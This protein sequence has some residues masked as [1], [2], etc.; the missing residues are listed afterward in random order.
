M[1]D[2]LIRATEAAIRQV[3]DSRFFATE[4]GFH[5]RFYCALQAQLERQ[6]ILVDG[7]IL[8][9]EYQKSARH[10]IG[11]RPDIVL[12][13]PA[14]QSGMSVEDNNFAVWAL[15][16]KANEKEAREDFRKLDE[17]FEYLHYPL[18]FFMNIASSDPL[19]RFY[20]GRYRDRLFAVAARREESGIVSNWQPAGPASLS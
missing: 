15:K 19:H 3:D 20:D 13:V 1:R 9:M 8:E 12:H 6:D 17:M 2:A 18:G 4:R 5:G 14:E 10:Q 11:Q 7:R 16:F